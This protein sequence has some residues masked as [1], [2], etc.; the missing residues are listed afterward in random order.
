MSTLPQQLTFP[1]LQT[2]WASQLNPVLANLL[3]NGQL[4]PS[5]ALNNGT[6]AINHKLGRQPQGWFLIAPQ[7]AATVYQAAQQTNPTLTL[8]FVS[9]AAITTGFWVF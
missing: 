5:I 6:T 8:T 4:L 2:T 7:G 1:Q 9:D 3:I